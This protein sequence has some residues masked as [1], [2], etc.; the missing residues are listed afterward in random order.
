MQGK[1][2]KNGGKLTYGNPTHDHH[3]G[4]SKIV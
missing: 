1:I 3:Q 4:S 2:K